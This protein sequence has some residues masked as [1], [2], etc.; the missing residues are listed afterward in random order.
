MSPRSPVLLVAG[1]LTTAATLA[2][3]AW[4]RLRPVDV[5]RAGRWENDVVVCPDDEVDL[6]ALERA[7][8]WWRERGHVIRIDCPGRVTVVTDPTLDT[9]DSVDDP[10]LVHGRTRVW[11]VGPE[12]ASAEIRVLPDAGPLVLAHEI[13][14]ALGY[15]HPWGAPTGHLMHSAQPGWDGRGLEVGP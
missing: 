8:D 5:P 10:D 3:V 2:V 12:I 6:A 4:G 7:A 1:L 9:R 14:H 15:R 11:Q 13:G